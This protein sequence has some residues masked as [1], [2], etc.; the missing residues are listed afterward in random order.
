MEETATPPTVG[1]SPLWE[2]AATS[3]VKETDRQMDN[4]RRKGECQE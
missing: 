3:E 1:Y 4:Q 2:R